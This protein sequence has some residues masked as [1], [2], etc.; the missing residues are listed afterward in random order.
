MRI[1]WRRLTW[2]LVAAVPLAVIVGLVWAATRDL[3]AI[4]PG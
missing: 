4:R 1:P 2:L 3:S